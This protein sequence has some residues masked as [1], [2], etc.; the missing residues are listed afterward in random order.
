M[1]KYLCNGCGVKLKH[2]S[3]VAY[4]VTINLKGP[5]GAMWHPDKSLS[6][7]YEFCYDCEEKAKEEFEKRIIQFNDR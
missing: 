2:V 6:Q 1:K 5:D 4:Q 7:V 3:E